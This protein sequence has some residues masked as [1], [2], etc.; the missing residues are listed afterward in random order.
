MYDAQIGRWHVIDPLSELDRKTT[1]YAYV[2][3]NPLL[4]I[5]PDG[6]FGDY[7]KKDG[8]Y[9]GNDGIDDDKVYTVENNAV[10]TT[11]NT[12]GVTINLMLKSAITDITSTTGVTHTDFLKLAAVTYA[13]SSEKGNY[14][15]EKFGIASA[16]V[17]NFEARGGKQTLGKVLSE[18]SN[19]TFD[20]NDRYE[21]F[22]NST[23]IGRSS[24]DDMKTSSA[25]AIN[26]LTGGIDYSNGAT[27]WDGR[28]LKTNS[29][30]IGLNISSPSHDLYK[31]GDRP[32]GKMEN[33]SSYRRQTTAAFGE[34]VFIRIHPKFVKGGGRKY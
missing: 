4:F 6:M 29:H 27:G 31:V 18:I 22:N 2:F 19:A 21:A 10:R 25:A 5:D 33:G 12:K 16:S 24:N 28:D 32:L 14:R 11:T 13:E 9:L 3:N 20:G 8:T 23:K 34:S 30:R 17:N 7:Y 26:A 1:P 15:E